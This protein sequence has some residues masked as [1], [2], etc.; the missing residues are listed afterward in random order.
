MVGG[1]KNKIT[2]LCK[3]KATKKYSKPTRGYNAFGSQKKPRKSKLKKQSKDII[4]AI[5]DRIIR[6]IKISLRKKKII[7]NQ[8]K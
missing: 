5:E 1:V 3:T 4:K 8:Y 6:D 2:S 7:T